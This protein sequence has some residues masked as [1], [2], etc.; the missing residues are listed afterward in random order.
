MFWKCGTRVSVRTLVSTSGT[1]RVSLTAQALL[2]S[3]LSWLVDVDTFFLGGGLFTTTL[4]I[5]AVSARQRK[6]ALC[7][8]IL[9]LRRLS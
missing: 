1:E 6:T 5:G 3:P 7:G 9:D 4:R 8:L 2:F